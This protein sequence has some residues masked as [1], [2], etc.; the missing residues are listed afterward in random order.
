MSDEYDYRRIVEDALEQCEV[1]HKKLHLDA[2][3][4]AAIYGG[5]DSCMESLAKHNYDKYQNASSNEITNQSLVGGVF[6]SL[7]VAHSA[8]EERDLAFFIEVVSLVTDSIG[9]LSASAYDLAE[10]SR[11]MSQYARMGRAKDP[12]QQEKAFIRECWEDWKN[13]PGNYR[14]KAAFARDMLNKCQHI[15]SQKKIEDWCR[16][17]ERKN[18]HSAS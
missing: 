10:R 14:S 2:E 18:T 8:L 17:W 1:L 12:K 7:G 15:V 4:L 13:N 9:S 5:L 16:E 3:R 6:Y 11:L